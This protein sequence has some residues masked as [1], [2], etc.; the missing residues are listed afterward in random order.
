MLKS[1]CVNLKLQDVT[2]LPPSASVLIDSS[3]VTTS[4][5]KPT[6]QDQMARKV[7]RT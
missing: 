3:R 7:S 2:E 6:H 1:G 5:S 4:T